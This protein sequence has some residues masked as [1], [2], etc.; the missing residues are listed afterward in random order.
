MNL[1]LNGDGLMCR[2]Q[3]FIFQWNM[4]RTVNGTWAR[5]E[6][7]GA[8]SGAGIEFCVSSIC[9]LYALFKWAQNCIIYSLNINQKS[10]YNYLFFHRL[11]KLMFACFDMTFKKIFYLLF[12]LLLYNSNNKVIYK[13]LI[14]HDNLLTLSIRIWQNIIFHR[15]L[16]MQYS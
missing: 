7:I 9:E 4:T 14:F 8:C 1:S 16:N 10:I 3:T 13:M 6:L 15:A 11:P 12:L 2:V 5:W